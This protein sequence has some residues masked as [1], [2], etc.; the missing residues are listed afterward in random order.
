MI[1]METITNDDEVVTKVT[2]IS[3]FIFNWIVKI[4]VYA[5]LFIR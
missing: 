5:L 3:N 1:S 2:A 4:A